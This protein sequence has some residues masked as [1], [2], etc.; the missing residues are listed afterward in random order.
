MEG[1]MA[2]RNSNTKQPK[3]TSTRAVAD[4][5]AASGR[6][7]GKKTQGAAAGARNSRSGKR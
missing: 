1:L 6:G 4:K 5:P 2:T 3:R 7:M